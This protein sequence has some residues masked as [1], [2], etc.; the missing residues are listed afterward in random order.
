ML[1]ELRSRHK[2]SPIHFKDRWVCVTK[3][4]LSLSF[5]CN[6]PTNFLLNDQTLIACSSKN[7]HFRYLSGYC[8][9]QSLLKLDEIIAYHALTTVMN[10]ITTELINGCW[11]PLK[12]HLPQTLRWATGRPLSHRAFVFH[13]LSL[14]G[15][16]CPTVSRNFIFGRYAPLTRIWVR[17]Y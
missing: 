12:L 5:I 13:A 9:R 8:I 4:S 15:I 6:Q 11:T 2:R 14:Y 1:I 10:P 17:T 3:R 16:E 7:D